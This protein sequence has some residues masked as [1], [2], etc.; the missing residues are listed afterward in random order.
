MILDA[1]LAFDAYTGVAITVTRDSTNILDMKSQRD[2]GAGDNVL[3]L[4]IKITETF[5]AAGAATLVTQIMGAA[6]NAGVPAAFY[7]L[8][9]T[10]AEAVANL[11]LGREI[12]KV[13]LPL[14]NE[15]ASND[16]LNVPRFY[17]LVYTV[18]TGPMTAGKVAS[19]L[20]GHMSRDAN[21][22]YPA[23]FSAVYI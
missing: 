11:T 18:A 15:V 13:P 19:Y 5:T 16:G 9:Q 12:L 1:L 14:W 4:L 20:I 17:K 2:M 8:A 6:D 3:D 21:H 7:P 23:G 10:Q 22:S